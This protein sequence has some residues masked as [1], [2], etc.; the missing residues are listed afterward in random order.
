MIIKDDDVFVVQLVALAPDMQ[1]FAGGSVPVDRREQY[2]SKYPHNWMSGGKRDPNERPVDSAIREGY[3]EGILIPEGA[4]VY[5]VLRGVKDGFGKLSGTPC[6]FSIVVCDEPIIWLKDY[7]EK[8]RGVEQRTLTMADI[9]ALWN[10]GSK[11]DPVWDIHERVLSGEKN[12][13]P[14]N[15]NKRGE[16][17]W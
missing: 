15:L 4:N 10:P 6:V 16:W 14:I 13:P 2:G 17:I 11:S 8:Y 3:E 5:E 9:K 7:K 1:G 12:I